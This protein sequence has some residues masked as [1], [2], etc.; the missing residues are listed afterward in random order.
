MRTHAVDSVLI[1][2]LIEDSALYNSHFLAQHGLSLLVETQSG[3]EWF[4]CL[5]DVG[6]DP[7]TLLHNAELLDISLE[8]LDAIL[9]SHCHWDH[10]RGAT[11]I[12][13]AVGKPNLPVYAHPDIFRPHFKNN[14]PTMHLGVPE[15]DGKPMIEASGG[16][17]HFSNKPLEIAPGV[18][19]TGEV[20]RK[21]PFEKVPCLQTVQ[22]GEIVPDN[23][24]DDISM[25]INVKGRGAI[26]VSGCSH[27]GI[28][29]ICRWGT[30]FLGVG[31]E[32]LVG[33]LHLSNATDH[34][35]D[36]TVEGL[37][38]LAPSWLAPG[39]CTGFG[40][41]CS[42]KRSFGDQMVPLT[43]GR[44]LKIGVKGLEVLR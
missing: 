36:R 17:L 22:N 15:G 4:R 2:V 25:V 3:E 14:D 10:T 7:E 9:L 34:V 11:Q 31:L 23:L 42:L 29:N 18:W 13:S 43:S 35:V 1:T 19:L 44:K 37:Q 6:Q 32:G 12:V 8:S 26:V 20:P 24:D 16:V 28:V 21:T 5:V 33:G 39:H 40:A 41:M 30:E 38:E 27:S